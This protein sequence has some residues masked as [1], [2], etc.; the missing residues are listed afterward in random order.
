V[1]LQ[2]PD[3]CGPQPNASAGASPR[4][5]LTRTE[6][7]SSERGQ[8]GVVCILDAA[9]PLCNRRTMH[10]K[11]VRCPSLIGDRRKPTQSCKTPRPPI[12]LGSFFADMPTIEKIIAS[13]RRVDRFLR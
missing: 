12:S 4:S 9:V 10:G 5:T 13:C 3:K 1:K 6:I 2:T 8:I 11:R 7:L